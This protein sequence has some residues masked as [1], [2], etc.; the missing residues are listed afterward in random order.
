[1]CEKFS[2]GVKLG[3]YRHFKGNEYEVLA[4]GYD[5]ET[6][7]EVVIYK[8]LYGKGDIWVRSKKMFFEKVV[9]D[10]IEMP[11]FEYIG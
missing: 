3:K 1:M 2:K 9:K 10:G 7:E 8:A 6:T 4:V 11:R 5:S